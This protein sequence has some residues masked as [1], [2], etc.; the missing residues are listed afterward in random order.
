MIDEAYDRLGHAIANRERSRLE[1]VSA[2]ERLRA[3]HLRL[4]DAV[5][6]LAW[7]AGLHQRNEAIRGCYWGLTELTPSEIAEAFCI[8]LSELVV[9]AG[10]VE[11]HG[12]R[13][14]ACGA[15]VIVRSRKAYTELLAGKRPPFCAPHERMAREEER[16]PVRMLGRPRQRR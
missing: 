2:Q 3:D 16:P 8:T 15:E 6:D 11:A 12:I 14:A 4:V 5:R 13:C 1:A 10:P 7:A 9:I